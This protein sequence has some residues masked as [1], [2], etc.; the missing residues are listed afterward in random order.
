MFIQSQIQKSCTVVLIKTPDNINRKK[1]IMIYRICIIILISSLLVNVT[2][3]SQTQAKTFTPQKVFHTIK[4]GSK[5]PSIVFER[6]VNH[7]KPKLQISDFKGKAIILDFWAPWCTPCIKAFPH[8][9]SIQKLFNKD[10]QIIMLSREEAEYSKK[11]FDIAVKNNKIGNFPLIVEDSTIAFPKIIP[12]YIWIGKDGIVKGITS[13]AEVTSENVKQFIKGIDIAFP[14]KEDRLFESEDRPMFSE[15]PR[16]TNDDLLFHSILTKHIIGYSSNGSRGVNWNWVRFTRHPIIS[17]YKVAYG[18]FSMEYL[19]DNRVILEGFKTEADSFLIGR[20][21]SNNIGRW[22]KVQHDHYYNYELVIPGDTPSSKTEKL[23]RKERI[24][25]MM[26]ADLNRYFYIFGISGKLEKRKVKILTLIR[27]STSDKLKSKGGER[28]EIS[29]EQYLEIKNM[30]IKQMVMKLQA[31]FFKED[32][33]PIEDE[34]DY[35]NM[36]DITITAE[37]QDI[38]EVNS[39]LAKYDLKFVEKEKEISMVIIS[40]K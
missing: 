10:L 33:L 14:V 15:S 8:L 6:V 21:T 26:Q 30:P 39:E 29:S 12:H 3:Y 20:F 27:T 38:K 35:K 19:N 31:F 1:S 34:T 4:V 11:I 25:E 22:N 7:T 32:A 28:K 2:L 36:I 9:D 23:E 17:L 5:F 18:K 13:S 37:L 16:Y 40:K 24:F